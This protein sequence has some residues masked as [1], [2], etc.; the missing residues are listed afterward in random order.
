MLI[1][2]R[3]MFIGAVAGIAG[4]RLGVAEGISDGYIT[5]VAEKSEMG[6]LD[7][8]GNKTPVWRFA[9]DKP[10]AVVRARQG[11]EL[12][13]RLINLLDEEIWLHWFGVRGRSEMMTLNV[14]PGETNSLEFSFTPPDAGTF[15]FGPLTNASKQ[16]D[17]GLYG[18]LIVE[19]AQPAGF[20]DIPLILDDWKIDDAGQLL[21]RFGDLEAA[22]GEGRMGNWFTLNGVFKS[23]TKVDRSKPARLRLLN[24]ANV[25]QMNVL[26]KGADLYVM[27][28]DGQPLPLKALGQ[29]ALKLAPGQRVDLLLPDMKSQIVVALDL[30]EDIVEIGY[31]EPQGVKVT[32]EL[33]E[34]FVLPAN[35][36]SPLPGTGIPKQVLIVIAGG[37]KG[38]LKSAKVGDQEL[39]LRAMLAKGL[40]WAFNGIS[41]VGGP[42]L[43]EAAKGDTL[44]LT[45][46]NSTSFPQPIH[47]HGHVW[48]LVETDGQAVENQPWRDTAVVPGLSKIKLTMVADNVGVWALQ[49]LVAERVDSGLIGSFTVHEA[50][51]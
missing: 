48:Q 37:A 10:I 17:M 43:F 32:H 45:F 27:A 35:P 28:L 15:W 42:A 5:L 8:S 21:G 33:P 14:L 20:V 34:N 36:L 47:I 24:A 25:R 39:D 41:G 7:K 12:K 51:P 2:R 4:P 40:A 16:R 19:E 1:S 50:Q 11:Q 44:I 26:F 49:S 31:L 13:G 46:D 30:F 9:K 18:M 3:Q 6:L 22:I 38:G 29:E 23:H